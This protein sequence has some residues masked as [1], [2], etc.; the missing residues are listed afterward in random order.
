MTAPGT[1]VSR[2]RAILMREWRILWIRFLMIV[3]L[4]A[5]L[6]QQGLRIGSLMAPAMLIGLIMGMD[7]GT[8]DRRTGFDLILLTLPVSQ[9]RHQLIRFVFRLILLG[10]IW[11]Y[12]RSLFPD[13]YQYHISSSM[14]AFW[15]FIAF[16]GAAAASLPSRKLI[17]SACLAAG[18]ILG[19]YLLLIG[20]AYQF[21]TSMGPLLMVAVYPNTIPV[22]CSIVMA[23]MLGVSTLI[24][25]GG[26]TRS[27][28]SRRMI[29]M[30][31]TVF[32]WLGGAV[33]CSGFLTLIPSYLKAKPLEAATRVIL[34]GAVPGTDQVIMDTVLGEYPMG[35]W[36]V[37]PDRH[38]RI[39]DLRGAYRM[40]STEDRRYYAAHTSSFTGYNFEIYGIDPT[41]QESVVRK[42]RSTEDL[43]Y[44]SYL[45]YKPLQVS[46]GR[47]RAAVTVWSHKEP[48]HIRVMDL[49]NPDGD[50][51]WQKD[52][53]GSRDRVYALGWS[54]DETVIVLVH[55]GD[56]EELWKIRSDV[57][58]ECFYTSE[59][60]F[61][62]KEGITRTPVAVW[63][64]RRRSVILVQERIPAEIIE[65]GT[66]DPRIP[67]MIEVF[68]D[69][70]IKD[71]HPPWNSYVQV[72]LQSLPCDDLLLIYQ[73]S[74]SELAFNLETGVSQ[75]LQLHQ[76]DDLSPDCRFIATVHSVDKQRKLSVMKI[77]DREALY[78]FDAVR[79]RQWISGNRLAF[80]RDN[81]QLEILDID[82]G[83]VIPICDFNWEDR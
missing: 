55:L 29:S 39:S 78:D 63:H 69:G 56:R 81:G 46:P 71:H 61:R 25:A 44:L 42:M 5:Y 41:A 65:D 26:F 2:I 13:T 3:F 52:G 18:L 59:T 51:T 23:V 60:G 67:R 28:H 9:R 35:T 76:Q 72:D 22:F 66:E 45:R 40:T 70:Q 77:D 83:T 73:G 7:L 53:M 17:I 54:D 31:Q 32:L 21:G 57:P 43:I 58:A 12:I 82:S 48:N 34:W 6:R 8:R 36:V 16:L 74:V 50:W 24:I 38:Y 64:P 62:P 14:T 27:V 75:D 15:L 10:V 19:W 4:L 49:Q 37:G 11:V 79:D 33:I 20:T 68:S 47:P 80:L 1:G 30:R